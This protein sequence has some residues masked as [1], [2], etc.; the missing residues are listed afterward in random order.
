MKELIRRADEIASDAAPRRRIDLVERAV[1]A[2]HTIEFADL[3]YDI[4]EEERVDP[5]LAFELV[6]NEVGVREL[7]PPT[8]DAWTEAQ[9]EAPPEWVARP[10][11]SPVAAPERHLRVTFRRLRSLLDQH[12]S[13]A[14]ALEAFANQPDVAEMKY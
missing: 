4:A 7:A 12:D 8:Q 1:A 6:L 11:A 13:A 10:D 14:A 5:A 2:G 9:V 3:I